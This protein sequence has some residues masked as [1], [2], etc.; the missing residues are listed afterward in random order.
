MV[1][2]GGSALGVL[3]W[4]THVWPLLPWVGSEGE[5]PG[6]LSGYSL[7][8][9]CLWTS[10]GGSSYSGIFR[11]FHLACKDKRFSAIFCC[12]VVV[13]FSQSTPHTFALE[14]IYVYI[15][16][17]RHMHTSVQTHMYTFTGTHTCAQRHTHAHT[18][19]H[20]HIYTR[21]FGPHE[22]REKDL[23]LSWHPYPCSLSQ[24]LAHTRYSTNVYANE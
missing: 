8:H 2:G 6:D 15:G 5:I 7:P 21:L 13:L 11:M 10:R 9:S 19:T 3:G 16:K 1:W 17:Y 14:C 23:F 18:G 4:G 20:M 12:G 22:D 24:C